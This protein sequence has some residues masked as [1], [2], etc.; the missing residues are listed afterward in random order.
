MSAG[1]NHIGKEYCGNFHCKTESKVDECIVIYYISRLIRFGNFRWSNKKSNI[2]NNR[3]NLVGRPTRWMSAIKI[4]TIPSLLLLR[5][6]IFTIRIFGICCF[7]MLSAL[8][9][10][11]IYSNNFS[12]RFCIR[13]KNPIQLTNHAKSVKNITSAF[14]LP[15]K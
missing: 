7:S 13:L 10:L 2:I 4:F 5:F 15:K 11:S 6:Q 1:I 8:F 9:V 14:C 12:I 3:D